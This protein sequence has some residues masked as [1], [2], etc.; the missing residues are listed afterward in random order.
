MP[1]KQL[2]LQ[3]TQQF[4]LLLSLQ[5][6]QSLSAHSTL[7]LTNFLVPWVQAYREL[8]EW[9]SGAFSGWLVRKEVSV[10]GQ[11]ALQRSL[12]TA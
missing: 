9:S 2:Q 10:S 11:R 8:P 12:R 5:W 3:F 6:A 4:I 7:L 1:H